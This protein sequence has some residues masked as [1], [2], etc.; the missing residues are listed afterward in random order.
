VK[1]FPDLLLPYKFTLTKVL[2]KEV[3]SHLDIEKAR[4]TPLHPQS[5]GMV[6]RLNRTLEA[7]VSKFVLEKQRNW[8]QLLPLLTM[9]YQSAMH[10]STGC[11]PNELMFRRDVRLP[12]DIMCRS[13]AVPVT[14][15]HSTNFAWNLREQVSKIHQLARD[16]L[17]IAA[18]RRQKGLYDQRFQAN[19]YRMGKKVWLY[20]HNSK[21]GRNPKL[22]T[23]WEG[24]WEI[25]KQV[26]DAVHRIQ[27]TSYGKPK[28]V[29]HDCLEP[30]HER[31][32]SSP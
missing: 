23:L 6:Q 11:T 32:I 3:C 2:F 10:E 31:Q 20:N 17:N 27:R 8:D 5:D 15:P 14:P 13:P 22:H 18:S 19:F 9:A 24:P 28:F 12:V 25:T 21:K 1:S 30:F 29:H 7:V 4:T 16:N 26:T